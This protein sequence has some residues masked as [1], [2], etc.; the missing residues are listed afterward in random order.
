MGDQEYSA[1]IIN[2]FDWNGTWW[3]WKPCQ[4]MIKAESYVPPKE[5]PSQPSAHLPYSPGRHVQIY[6]TCFLE[7]RESP[8]LATSACSE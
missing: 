4:I 2:R 7:D 1:S 5:R 6:A 3:V 8:P